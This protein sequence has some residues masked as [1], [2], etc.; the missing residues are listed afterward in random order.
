MT[1]GLGGLQNN[2]LS[3][4]EVSAHGRTSRVVQ[5]TSSFQNITPVIGGARRHVN[6]ATLRNAQSSP[7]FPE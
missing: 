4:A 2:S 7:R 5:Y 3:R 1:E 6:N